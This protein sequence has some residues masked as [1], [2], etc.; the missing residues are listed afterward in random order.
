[1]TAVLR[2]LCHSSESTHQCGDRC[3][4]RQSF[5]H[6]ITGSC[7]GI[8]IPIPR[9]IR[10]IAGDEFSQVAPVLPPFDQDSKMSDGVIAVIMTSNPPNAFSTPTSELHN[11]RK[12]PRSYL[13]LKTIELRSR[14]TITSSRSNQPDSCRLHDANAATSFQRGEHNWTSTQRCYYC[15]KHWP[16]NV[17]SKQL[18]RLYGS[19]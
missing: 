17:C 12:S 7:V 13:T 6:V 19:E 14:F 18:A 11:P 10:P 16:R 3:C 1:M 15:M 5:A 4:C 9:S 2:L 8:T